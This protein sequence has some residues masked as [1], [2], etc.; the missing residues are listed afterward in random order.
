[1]VLEESRNGPRGV[2]ESQIYIPLGLMKMKS[3]PQGIQGI[4]A[5][6]IVVD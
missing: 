1:M 3:I 2:E 4:I 6:F 5:C